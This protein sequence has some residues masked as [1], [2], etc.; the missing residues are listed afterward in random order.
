MGLGRGVGGGLGR[1]VE[2]GVPAQ[3]EPCRASEH[4][5]A[6]RPPFPGAPPSRCSWA[7]S[8]RGAAAF[9][10]S[11]VAGPPLPSSRPP[12]GRRPRAPSR[13]GAVARGRPTTAR[14]GAASDFPP[15]VRVLLPLCGGQGAWGRDAPRSL[16]S[17][18]PSPGAARMCAQPRWMVANRQAEKAHMGEPGS[19]RATGGAALA[20]RQ[21]RTVC[22]AFLVRSAGRPGCRSALMRRSGTRC[23]FRCPR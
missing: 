7:P 12:R 17:A 14:R 1:R 13:R 19:D 15:C 21:R 11:P 20:G 18:P 16:A 2:E 6:P 5:A 4:L 23:F 9:E 3:R 8:C 22:A 10:T